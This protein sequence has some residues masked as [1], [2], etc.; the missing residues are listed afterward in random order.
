MSK[1]FGKKKHSKERFSYRNKADCLHQR[2]LPSLV[3]V[4]VGLLICI[5]PVCDTKLN[6]IWM[7]VKGFWWFSIIKISFGII[8]FLLAWV[9]LADL[10]SCHTGC[11]TVSWFNSL[12]SAKSI[13]CMHICVHIYIWQMP[14]GGL[15]R[16]VTMWWGEF[17]FLQLYIGPE[18]GVA[19]Q[20]TKL[21]HIWNTDFLH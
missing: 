19:L 8:F 4:I 20:A 2:Y 15:P 1:H 5:T 13:C 18:S 12:V 6:V 21:S 3:Q 10:W 14:N 17:L 16:T 7:H 9:V 11:H